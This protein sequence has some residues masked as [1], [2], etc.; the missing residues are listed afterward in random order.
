M[1]KPA[2][3]YYNKIIDKRGYFSELFKKNHFKFSFVQDNLVFN[4][5]KNTFRGMHYQ[6]K[7]F[8]QG[9]LLTVL[10]GSIIDYIWKLEK[11]SKK[12]VNIK[13]FFLSEKDNKWLWVPPDFAHGYLTCEDNTLIFYKVTKHYSYKHERI[14]NIFKDNVNKIMNIQKSKIITSKKDS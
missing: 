12:K 6:S 1:K 2:L 9:K 10:R 7:P 4:K 8:E 11:N 14:I 13:K 5:K 3:I